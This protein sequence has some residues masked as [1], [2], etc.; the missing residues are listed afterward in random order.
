MNFDAMTQEI[1][2]SFRTHGF[3]GIV[4]FISMSP[5]LLE[6]PDVR[7]A[8]GIMVDAMKRA[9]EKIEPLMKKNFPGWTAA[10]LEMFKTT[11]EQL[12]P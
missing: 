8:S 9:N 4:Y 10:P 2:T 6:H 11:G 3:A 12:R 5:E 7:E 1:C